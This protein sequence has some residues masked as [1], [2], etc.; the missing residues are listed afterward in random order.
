MYREPF[1]LMVDLDDAVGIDQLDRFAYMA[2]G[3]TV[4]VFVL[5]EIDMAVLVYGTTAIPFY[6]IT[7]F[8][9][10]H[11]FIFFHFEEQ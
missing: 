7:F 10:G 4:I 5:P 3:N 11:Q 8:E 2:V 1:V 9:Q 6:L